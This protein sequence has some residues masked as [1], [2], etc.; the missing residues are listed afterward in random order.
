[1]A[2]PF[3]FPLRVRFGECDPQGIVFNANY[4]GYFDH[5]FTELW[6]EAFGSY[7]SMVERGV[8]MVL[9][10]VNL[11]FT[12]SGRFDDLVEIELTIERLGTTSMHSRLELLREGESLVQARMRH[13]LVDA[14]S[15]SKTEFP[16]WLREGLAP[17][18]AA[19]G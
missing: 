17:Y 11:T 14:R 9:A 18:V 19:A 12:G 3:S 6:R 4:L 16:A 13:V 10:E 15:W 8:D 2:A 7:A 5:A 1:M